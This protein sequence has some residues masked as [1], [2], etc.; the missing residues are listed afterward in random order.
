[1]TSPVS[2]FHILIVL[3]PDPET[4][5]LPSGEKATDKTSS[6]WPDETYIGTLNIFICI[7][8]ILK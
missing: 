5:A 1:M 3:S 7:D 2:G 4:I 6:L 8:T